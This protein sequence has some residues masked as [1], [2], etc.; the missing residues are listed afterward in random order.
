[1]STVSIAGIAQSHARQVQASS[2]AE[3]AAPEAI[4]FA[5]D[6]A[7]IARRHLERHIDWLAH[8]GGVRA[9]QVRSGSWP[10][11]RRTAGTDNGEG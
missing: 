1:V 4:E 10:P 11:K 5:L 8:L 3:H 9:E 6:E 2:F 7:R